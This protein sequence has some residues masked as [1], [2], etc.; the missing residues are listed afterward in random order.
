MVS[1]YVLNKIILENE[2]Y[3]VIFIL[4]PVMAENINFDEIANN[5]S[6]NMELEEVLNEIN[7]FPTPIL[8]D[9]DFADMEE[10]L[11][12]VEGHESE[13][14]NSPIAPTSYATNKI[15]TEFI[16]ACSV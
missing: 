6:K 4:S 14:T 10:L 7:E 11:K 15:V 2:L 13:T 3:D 8:T 5:T 1:L 16:G 12:K 9:E